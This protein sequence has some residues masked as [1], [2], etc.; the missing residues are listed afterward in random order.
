MRILNDNVLN[1]NNTI[2]SSSDAD[3][4]TSAMLD[5]DVMY[6]GVFNSKHGTLETTDSEVKTINSGAILN[7]NADFIVITLYKS[8]SEKIYYTV[9]PKDKNAIFNFEKIK[10]MKIKVDFHVKNSSEN[11]AIGYI[12]LGLAID[13]PPHAPEK[14]HK[15][16][17]TSESF[18]SQSGHYFTRR[19][20]LRQ[21]NEWSVSFPHLTNNDKELIENFFYTN[22]SNSF[23]LQVW[24]EVNITQFLPA[25]YGVGVYGRCRYGRFGN[26]KQA[27]YGTAV[28]GGSKYGNPKEYKPVF[29]MT[30][31]LY[32]ITNNIL[33]FKKS[34]NKIYQWS[35]TL[36]FREVK[37]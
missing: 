5:K 23:I 13:L 20:P 35:L 33:E 8:E 19:L 10:C 37:N 36:N 2:F 22:D 11:I 6:Q 7:T 26:K 18:F 12:S 29:R 9:R 14:T 17:L 25:Y 34:N 24:K 27:L 21:Y 28:Y 15:V 32:I 31:G 1:T 16:N 30:S 3:N 4:E